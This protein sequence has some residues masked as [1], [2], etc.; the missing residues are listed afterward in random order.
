[1]GKENGRLIDDT[2]DP[3]GDVYDDEMS[4]GDSLEKGEEPEVYEGKENPRRRSPHE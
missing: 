1:M 3:T 2:R 4:Q